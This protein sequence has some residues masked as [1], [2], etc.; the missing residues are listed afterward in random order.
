MKK[1]KKLVLARANK[2]Q[3]RALIRQLKRDVASEKRAAVAQHIE[4]IRAVAS[5]RNLRHQQ[6]AAINSRAIQVREYALDET[7]KFDTG[8]QKSANLIRS[9]CEYIPYGP[10]GEWPERNGIHPFRRWGLETP[11][12]RT[13]R[14]EAEEEASRL[15]EADVAES[16][17]T[18]FLDSRFSKTL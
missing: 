3:L 8:M 11:E 5:E 14:K 12:E 13:A 9:M 15:T 2:K 17:V 7:F 6:F 16:L 10:S 18:G 4:G 1:A